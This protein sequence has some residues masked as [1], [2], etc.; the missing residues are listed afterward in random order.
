MVLF[1]P[2]DEG[3]RRGETI[4]SYIHAKLKLFLVPR[5]MFRRPRR[6][7]GRLAGP[8]DEIPDTQE[9][10]QLHPGARGW[11]VAIGST[12]VCGFSMPYL[13]SAGTRLA[14]LKP[15]RRR[16][17]KKRGKTTKKNRRRGMDP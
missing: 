8:K 9:R 1:G 14:P 17:Q 5:L 3:H 4:T 16:P 15:A 12:A 13:G 2:V 7:A 10:R 6:Q 11:T